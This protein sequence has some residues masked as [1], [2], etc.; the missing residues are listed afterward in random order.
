MQDFTQLA[1]FG[2]AGLAVFLMYKISSNH[3]EHLTTAITELTKV[4]TELKEWLH[5]HK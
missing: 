1:N 4:I 5:T 2:V 3:I